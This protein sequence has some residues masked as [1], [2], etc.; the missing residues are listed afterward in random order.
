MK[1]NRL[2]DMVAH[3]RQR[4]SD[5]IDADV[6]V[7][8]ALGQ[9]RAYLYAHDDDILEDPIIDQIHQLI[10]R[11]ALGEPVAYLLGYKEFYGRRFTVNSNVLI[12]RPETELLIEQALGLHLSTHAKLVDIGTGSGC[13]GL[14]LAAERPNWTVCVSDISPDALAVCQKNR[15][16]LNLTNVVTLQGALFQPWRDQQFDLIVANLPYLSPDDP[17]LNEGD[18]RHEP[19]LALVAQDQG[20]ALMADLIQHA[21]KHLI[22][23]GHILLE[24][25]FE[26]Q[27]WVEHMLTEAGFSNIQGLRDWAGHPRAVMATWL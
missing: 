16:D 23:G 10:K 11:R 6:L 2:K 25:G 13:I 3:A 8:H 20:Q 9:E 26:Q 5:R 24:H 21:P 7:A 15:Q 18:L 19:Q 17:H 1:N 22:C 12:P 4:L 14:T 27:D